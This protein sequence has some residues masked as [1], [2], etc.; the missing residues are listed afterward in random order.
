MAL[1]RGRRRRRHDR[2]WCRR[3]GPTGHVV[4]VDLETK[5]LAAL[6]Q[7]NLEVLRL[8]VTTDDLPD[9]AFDLI[10]ERAVLIH[11]PDQRAV[12]GRFMRALKPG[13]WL[14]CEDT[15]FSTLV[16]G[17][18]Y[19]AIRRVGAEMVRFFASRGANLNYGRH[20]YAALRSAGLDDVQADGRVYVMRGAHPSSTLPRYTFERVRAP[21]VASGALTKADFAEA[22]A[23]F[24]DAATALMSPVM[25]AAWGRRPAN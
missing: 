1:P 16:D 14:L 8:D 2:G 17:S 7:P 5:F 19:P 10:H 13:G 9:S 11:L 12:I 21:L 20:L 15:D 24:D 23:L 18:P 22:F 6:D 25:M 3:V 4:A